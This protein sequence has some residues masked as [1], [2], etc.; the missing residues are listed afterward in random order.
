[1]A[2]TDLIEYL[3]AE[4]LVQQFFLPFILTFAIFWG[5]LEVLRIFNRRINLVLAFGITIA[6]AYGGLFSFLSEVLLQLG[7]MAGIVAF[8]LVFIVGVVMWALGRGGDIIS[9]GRKARK[10]REKIEKLYEKASRTNNSAK[11]SAYIKEARRLED[12]Y[13]IEM[14]RNRM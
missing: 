2:T 8:T 10:L 7:A 11:R 13:Q 9:P 5:L 1:M 12:E 6:A 3:L 4:S 14:A